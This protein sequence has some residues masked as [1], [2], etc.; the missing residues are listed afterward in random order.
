MSPLVKR[1][2]SYLPADLLDVAAK[3]HLSAGFSECAKN[4]L[5]NAVWNEDRSALIFDYSDGSQTT[6]LVQGYRLLTKCSCKLWQPARNCPHVVI[7]WAI[8]KRTVTPG[9]LSHIRFNRQMLL[10][11]KEYLEREPVPAGNDAHT[12]L[13]GSNSPAAP[14]SATTADPPASAARTQFRLLFGVDVRSGDYSGRIMRDDQPVS[15]W[16]AMGVPTDLA[17][18]MAT[19][20]SY[21][22][23]PRYIETFLKLT[24]GRYPIMFHAADGLEREL[25]YHAGEIRRAGLV[26]EINNAEVLV[27]RCLDRGEHLPE[28]AIVDGA[29]LFVPGNGSIYP[30]ANCQLWQVL[31]NIANALKPPGVRTALQYYNGDGQDALGLNLFQSA[32][33]GVGV[34][35]CIP[36]VALLQFNAAG[37][38]FNRELFERYASDIFFFRNGEPLDIPAINQPTAYLLELPCGAIPPRVPLELLGQCDGHS[39]PFSDGVVRYLNPDRRRGMGDVMKHPKRVGPILEAGITLCF[40]KG[41]PDRDEV[42][43]QLRTKLDFL[44]PEVARDLEGILGALCGSWNEESVL[45]LAAPDGWKIVEDDRGKQVH[46]MRILIEQFGLEAFVSDPSTGGLQILHSRLMSKG[47]PFLSSLL[48]S[49]GFELR[50]GNESLVTA[51]WEFSL[52]ATVSGLDWFELK[53]EIRCDGVLLS[54]TELA[55]LLEGNGMLRRDG[56]VML[57][58]EAA[59]EAFALMSDSVLS[60]RRERS[61]ECEAIRVP[62]LQ[63]LDWLRLKKS[64]VTVSL[65][66]QEGALLDSL[67]NFESIPERPQPGGLMAELRHYQADAWRWLAFLYEHRFG[68]CLADDMGLGK[69]LQGITLLAGLLSGELASCAPPGSPHLVVA[70]P[71]LLFNWESELARFLPQAKVFIY[72]GAGRTAEALNDYDIVITSYGLVLRDMELLESQSFDV[73]IFDEAQAVKNLQASTSS[74]VRRL[75]GAFT[76][77]LTGTPVENHLREYYAIMDL[78]LPGLLGSIEDF[79]RQSGRGE[80]GIARLI[81]R[82]RPFILRRSKQMI[83]TEL[84]PKI[85]IDIQ[86]ELSEKQKALYQR[87]IEEVRGQVKDAYDKRASGQAGIIALTAILRLRQICLDPALISSESEE[88]PPKMEFLAEQLEELRDE[89]H[90]ALVFSQFTGY[91]DIVERGLKQ[92]GI[93]CLRLDGSTPVPKRKKLVQEFQDGEEPCVFLISLKAGGRGLNL[94]RA[95]YVYHMDPWWNPAVENQA[96]DRAHRIGQTGQVTITRLIMRHTV[97]EKMM[98][99]KEQK[100][101]LYQAILEDGV[102]GGGAGLSRKDFEYL[103][104]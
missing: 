103:L 58:D 26:F 41:A 66:P 24:N 81:G 62:R 50:V 88:I 94:T 52:D 8:T 42:M 96:S 38:R 93:A 84:P 101:K 48:Q 20:N 30:L 87:T 61:G 104:G 55:G 78:C 36:G 49:E 40:E 18:F 35:Q 57:L 83:A 69:T 5:K 82:T 59:A 85:E 21:Q 54:E 65:A 27:R 102:G 77:A 75:N 2:E 1:F 7:S 9:S 45:L 68:A 71:S 99:L 97:E 51:M 76:L 39:F 46:L 60:A 98:M 13:P 34:C 95:T 10:D 31:E 16:T 37:I 64:G 91:L 53:P 89:G 6:L 72:A 100:L 28:G 92:R 11:M 25:K 29:L 43:R 86:L 73:I 19:I 56:K 23:T 4:T 44:K 47:L 14:L 80:S 90:S 74:A 22:P 63:I 79:N 33:G 70:P 12:A 32:S 17:R 15:G 67:L 3:V